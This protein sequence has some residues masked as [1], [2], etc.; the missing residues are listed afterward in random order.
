[1]IVATAWRR[2]RRRFA[3]LEK[4]A[5]GLFKADPAVVNKLRD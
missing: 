3:E 1:V 5:R 2:S 4:V